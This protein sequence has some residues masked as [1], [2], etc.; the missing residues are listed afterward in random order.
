MKS[1]ILRSE[2]RNYPIGTGLSVARVIIN[3][4]EKNHLSIELQSISEALISSGHTSL[5]QQAKA[6]GVGR[7]TAWTI[8]KNKHKLGRLSAKTINR[9]L[10]NPQTPPAVRVVVQQYLAEKN[11]DVVLKEQLTPSKRELNHPLIHPSRLRSA[12]LLSQ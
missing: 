9:I 8:T 7:S 10:I 1:V 3:A 4:N 5:D 6:L 2:S 11:S 12:T